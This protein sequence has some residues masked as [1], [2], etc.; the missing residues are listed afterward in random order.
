MVNLILVFLVTW[1]VI[2][3][4]ATMILNAILKWV[5]KELDDPK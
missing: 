3:V 1:I 2:A 5:D 4:I